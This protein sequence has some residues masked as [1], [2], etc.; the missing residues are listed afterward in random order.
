MQKHPY[1]H[2]LAVLNAIR[3]KI[4]LRVAEVI[5]NQLKYVDNYKNAA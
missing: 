2:E 4:A 1:K 5:N 3:S